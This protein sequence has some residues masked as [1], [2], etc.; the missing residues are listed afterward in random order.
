MKKIF[1]QYYAC[2][3]GE[4]YSNKTRKYLKPWTDKKG[5]HRA[6]IS[7]KGKTKTWLWHRLISLAWYGKSE[8]SVDH[9][10]GN[11]KDNRPENLRYIHTLE[12]H[13]LAVASGKIRKGLNHYSSKFTK[14][15]V[16]KIRE[17]AIEAKIS[18]EKIGKM[19]NVAGSVVSRIKTG[20]TYG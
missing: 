18:Q 16:D 20:K 11:K 9:I 17:L 10:N 15:D 19:F 5:Y 4:I 6:K 13:R 1:D 3:T 7:I 12:N 2:S 14:E 8:L